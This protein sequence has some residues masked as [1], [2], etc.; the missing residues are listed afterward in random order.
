[1][2][3]SIFKRLD[4]EVFQGLDK[5]KTHPNYQSFLDFYT[6]LEDEQQKLFKS[7]V[8]VAM[9]LLPLLLVTVLFFQN[10]SLKSDYAQR[11]EIYKKANEILA[12]NQGV[13]DISSNI[14]SANPIDSAEMVIS[15]ISSALGP[16]GVDL[17]KIK[18][19]N[20]TSNSISSSIINSQAT[21]SFKDMSV[22]ELMDTFMGLIRREKFRIESIQ[23]LRN[24]NTNLLQGS[25]VG[26]H[27]SVISQD[28]ADEE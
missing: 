15:K 2:K 9:I 1:M 12:K 13:R 4:T 18:V 27:Y 25:F 5:L 24:E 23:I 26:T 28:A 8:L 11:V 10:Q 22:N 7:G 3:N 19:S 6:N 20:F 14:F 21:F 16:A 17:N